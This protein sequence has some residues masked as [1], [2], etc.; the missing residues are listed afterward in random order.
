MNKRLVHFLSA[1]MLLVFGCGPKPSAGDGGGESNSSAAPSEIDGARLVR[2]G[3]RVHVAPAYTGTAVWYYPN[4][5]RHTA[6][7]FKNGILD[8][9]MVSWYDDGQT[10]L[11][12]VKYKAN[13]KDGKATGYFRD[14]NPKFEINY[15]MG[16]RHSKET[17][18]H[19][20]NQKRFEFH[21]EKGK[22][23]AAKAWDP[24]GKEVAPPRPKPRVPL[25]QPGKQPPTKGNTPPAKKQTPP[26]N[27]GPEQK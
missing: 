24:A 22:Q 3:P 1:A 26:P 4:K 12:T 7:T 6:R 10:K 21:W 20:N 15:V 23:V 11:Y 27:K 2:L 5:N 8:G 14:G 17:W 25:K 19:T 13:R 18:W 16:V 9:P